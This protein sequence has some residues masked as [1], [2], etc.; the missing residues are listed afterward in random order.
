MISLQ[1][2]DKLSLSLIHYVNCLFQTP[3]T[4]PKK[5]GTF[6]RQTPTIDPKKLWETPINFGDPYILVSFPADYQI[7]YA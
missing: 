7:H 1:N 5:L 3:T 6:Y 2:R 4:A